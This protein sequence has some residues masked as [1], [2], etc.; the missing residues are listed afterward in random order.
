[1]VMGKTKV[2]PFKPAFQ[3][4]LSFTPAR[5]APSPSQQCNGSRACQWD[6]RRCGVPASRFGIS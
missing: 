3:T 2:W 4:P 5:S 6:V 1:M